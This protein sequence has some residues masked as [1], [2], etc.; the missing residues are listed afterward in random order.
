MEAAWLSPH[1]PSPPKI[2]DR[3]LAEPGGQAGR[4]PGCREHPSTCL[5]RF[6]SARGCLAGGREQQ[7]VL[8]LHQRAG[9]GAEG[10]EHSEERQRL[11]I[12]ASLPCSPVSSNPPPSPW[13]PSLLDWEKKKKRE[14]EKKRSFGRVP[15][16]SEGLVG[17]HL[18]V[19]LE[20]TSSPAG[21]RGALRATQAF[22]IT[23]AEESK[24]R[25][26][27]CSALHSCLQLQG[28]AIGLAGM[29]PSA[30]S[31]PEK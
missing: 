21:A 9:A 4:A 13:K 18:Y 2:W 26:G 1:A 29:T 25:G 17:W 14:K 23:G 5:G 16:I 12:P 22:L 3:A 6:D 20:Q 30:Q 15:A 24:A 28:H 7:R 10:V 8:W 19:T 11:R 31:L 27:F